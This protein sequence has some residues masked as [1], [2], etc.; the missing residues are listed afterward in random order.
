[1]PDPVLIASGLGFTEGP[2]WT[3]DGRLL[4]TSVSRGLVYEVDLAQ[5]QVVGEFETGG[6]PN[7]LAQDGTGAVWIAQ[8]GGVTVPSRSSRIV[9][10]GLQ[11]L[12]T[13]GA[14]DRLTTG[15]LAPN[16]LVE[17][18]DGRIWFTDPGGPN[19]PVPGRLC[20]FDRNTSHLDVLLEE[21]EF[22]NGLAFDL[23]GDVLHLAETRTGK[24]LRYRWDGARLE[25]QGVFATLPDGGADGMAVDA[26]GNLLV[27]IPAA[28]RI[29]V[30]TTDGSPLGEVRFDRPT[31]PTNLC[32]AGPDRDVLVVSA[33]KGGVL[34]AV[35]PPGAG[36]G[37]ARVRT[38]PP[39]PADGAAR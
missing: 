36:H 9:S 14:T 11:L 13:G 12:D 2:L 37:P 25:A 38:R 4:V 10:P 28:D 17:G 34:L 35:I 16:D 19:E 21:I 29:V 7:G 24:I 27:A 31:F 32:F 15:C 23:A 1:M 5:S 22:P 18:P 33:A 8:N 30:L 26:D 39:T 20:A 6:G 3:T